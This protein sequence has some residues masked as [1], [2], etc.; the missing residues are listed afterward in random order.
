MLDTSLS[1]SN[2]Y[3]LIAVAQGIVLSLLII[4]NRPRR[5]PNTYLG[6]LI[7]LFSL[8]LLHLILEESIHAF[9]SKFPVPMEFSWA[10]GPLA[11]LH[12]LHIKD[13]LRKFKRKDLLHFLPCLI[14]DVLLFTISFVYIGNN[15]DWA[16]QNI[17]LIQSIALSIISL[18]IVQLAIYS[19]FIYKESVDTKPVLKEFGQVRR[20]LSSLILSW[21][22]VIA[23]FIIAIP[24]GLMFIEEL[25]ENSEWLYKP[26]GAIETLMI[27]ILGYLYL[28]KYSKVIGDYMDKVSKFKFSANELDDKKNEILE[29][30]RQ[31]ELYKDPKITVAKLAGHLGWPINSVSKLINETLQTNFNDLINQF[32]VSA[33]KQLAVTPDSKKYSILGLGQE[34][35]FS[36][37]ASF[38][39][40]FK[41][42]TGMTPSE[43]MKSQA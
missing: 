24:I 8:A 33:F 34:V 12:I 28:M 14:F 6:V 38:Y 36:S 20:W 3:F 10:Y 22:I 29:A 43:F 27:Y 41:K 9:N 35:G 25:D 18:S 32:R 40:V 13:P 15:M 39:R 19:Y 16:Q 23:F 17:P 5:K 1:S 26:L 11:Y 31:Q 30:L 37:K 2:F 21:C 7:F 4:F 42:E